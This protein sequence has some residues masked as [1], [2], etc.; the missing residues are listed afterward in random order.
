[1]LICGLKLTHDGAIAL[2]R[3]SRLLFSIEVE[4]L[5]N[6]SRY[7]KVPDLDLVVDVLRDRGFVPADVDRWVVDG[8]DGRESGLVRTVSGGVPLEL[9]VA[10]YAELPDTDPLAVGATG[11]MP[12]GGL[13]V[14]YISFVHTSGHL[15]GAYLGSPSARA[16]RPAFVLVWDGGSF[17]R[18][19]LVERGTG[20]VALG[21]TFPLFGHAYA[22][23]G[24]HFG[25]YVRGAQPGEL[26][27]AGKL[28]AYI[29]KGRVSP[30][31]LEI[32]DRAFDEHFM[33]DGEL[34]VSYR[35]SVGGY[36]SHVE[37]SR[38]TTE[39]YLD[40]VGVQLARISVCGDDALTTFHHFL[41]RK[42]VESVM[43]TADESGRS[44]V[45]DLCLAGGCALNIKWNTALRRSPRFQSVWVPPYCNDSGSALGVALLGRT[46]GEAVVPFDWTVRSG[47]D[48]PVPP[49]P[50]AGWASRPCTPEQLAALLHERGEPVV[51]LYGAAE[52]GPRALGG[53]SILAPATQRETKDRLN[54]IKGREDY[55]PVAPVCIEE[56]SPRI[57]DPGTPDPYMLFDHRLRPG[58]AER[59]PA[60]VHLDGTARLETVGPNDD[61]VLRRV[62]LEY[63]RLSGV[64]VLCNTSANANGCGFFPDVASAAAWGRVPIIWSQGQLYV[65]HASS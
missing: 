38:E 41:E 21:A 50:P 12:L 36:G 10:G 3:D 2:L 23:A 51:V 46:P 4:K 25:P 9:P 55:R 56:E 47:P 33:D 48:L 11:R 59:V 49:A 58:W 54:A 22:L 42:L 14:P 15:A 35:K 53:R 64:P 28:M 43:Q 16:G 65:Q 30:A 34:A 7:S 62:L 61:P 31:A 5:A 27:V 44:D 57:F 29:A 52:L 37:P 19:Y 13:D 60:V 39:A 63:Y 24:F 18:L 8:W 1:M 20:A 45:V 6:N 40:D 32:F 17:P 26:W